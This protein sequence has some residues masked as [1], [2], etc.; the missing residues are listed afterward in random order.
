L[1][2][3]NLKPVYKTFKGWGQITDISSY[4]KLPEELK[5]YIRFIEESVG[6]PIKLV[7]MGPER[8]Q[9]LIR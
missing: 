4:D 1:G 6:V 9:T 7:S 8:N 3:A 2:A 5:Q